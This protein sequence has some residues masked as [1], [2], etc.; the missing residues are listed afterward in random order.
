MADDGILFG[1]DNEIPDDVFGEIDPS[2]WGAH[3]ADAAGALAEQSSAFIQHQATPPV[4][5]SQPSG[6]APPPPPPAR[7]AQPISRGR[8]VPA[9]LA[10]H[11]DENIPESLRQ[12]NVPIENTFSAISMVPTPEQV[13]CM[14][15]RSKCMELIP[16][17]HPSLLSSPN[18][19]LPMCF[20]ARAAEG[21]PI[22]IQKLLFFFTSVQNS[23][24]D[25]AHFVA[26]TV[27][28]DVIVRAHA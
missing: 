26:P 13:S 7:P 3:G 2:S 25:L 11:W 27:T 18:R 12:F 24:L 14:C 4:R 10:T 21:L 22:H 19:G 16:Q 6:P 23:M 28:T 1:S 8:R 17:D 15:A 5:P 9:S 20:V